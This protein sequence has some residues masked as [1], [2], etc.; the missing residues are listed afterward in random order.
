[1]SVAVCG[2]G[3]RSGDAFPSALQEALSF[4]TV[5]REFLAKDKGPQG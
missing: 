1:M 4:M 2:E 3:G 5:A